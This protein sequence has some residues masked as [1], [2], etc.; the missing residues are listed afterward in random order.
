MDKIFSDQAWC[1]QW[2]FF[3]LKKKKKKIQIYIYIYIYIFNL[4]SYYDKWEMKN[5]N[6]SS[7]YK[8]DYDY[9]WLTYL[10]MIIQM[11]Q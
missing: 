4:L 9:H 2:M 6:L 10:L 3:F 7:P 11:L 5:L 8:C 1:I